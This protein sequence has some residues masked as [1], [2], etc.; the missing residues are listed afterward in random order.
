MRAAISVLILAL[1]IAAAQAQ[2][3]IFGTAEPQAYHPDCELIGC[4][5]NLGRAIAICH[6][7]A[8]SAMGGGGGEYAFTYSAGWKDCLI[9]EKLFQQRRD[10]QLTQQRIEADRKLAPDHR[11][12]TDVARGVLK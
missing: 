8:Q 10:E 2:G 3:V 9:I 11:L 6:E 1:V 5:T 12:V 7:N 4:K